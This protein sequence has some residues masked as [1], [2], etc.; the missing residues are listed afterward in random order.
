MTPVYSY[1]KEA[2]LDDD[3][4]FTLDFANDIYVNQILFSSKY[5]YYI[6]TLNCDLKL[7]KDF[8]GHKGILNNLTKLSDLSQKL[9]KKGAAYQNDI[10]KLRLYLGVP[11]TIFAKVNYEF[12]LSNAQ[13]KHLFFNYQ[14]YDMEEQK[15]RD[16]TKYSPCNHF[17]E[18]GFR[19]KLYNNIYTVRLGELANSIFTQYKYKRYLFDFDIHYQTRNQLFV[20]DKVADEFIC[21]DGDYHLIINDRYQRYKKG[22]PDVNEFLYEYYWSIS[23]IT[24]T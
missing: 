19:C 18:R 2:L 17:S 10:K 11:G 1:F 12:W 16:C 13:I 23:Q 6:I 9:L 15:I 3:N 14:F 7:L 20:F 24:K 8:S 4:R 22:V 5:D 21:S